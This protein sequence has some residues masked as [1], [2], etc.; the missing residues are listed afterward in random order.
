[1]HGYEW[2][3]IAT[4]LA[5]L[6]YF[7]MSFRVGGARAKFKVE[8]PATTGDPIFE[9]H[10]RVHMNTLEWLPIFLP[11]LWMFA[12]YW[13]DEWAAGLG[14]VW[15][16]GRLIYMASYVKDPKTRSAGF[17]IQALA[18]LVLMVGAVWGAVSM[19]TKMSAVL[20]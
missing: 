7:V 3:T 17:G 20:V 8:A 15:I 2:T 4:V 9:R 18:T 10:F 12:G 14:A 16:V 11:C 13:R 5:L 19:L 1:M 6:T